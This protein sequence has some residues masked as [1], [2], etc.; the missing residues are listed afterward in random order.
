[1][2]SPILTT[3]NTANLEKLFKN[4]LVSPRTARLLRK[5]WND[6]E[7]FAKGV[8]SYVGWRLL[9]DISVFCFVIAV[10]MA[11]D[12]AVSEKDKTDDNLKDLDRAL[13]RCSPT[14][15]G[16]FLN[17]LASP[18][19]SKSARLEDV[20]K[21]Q[22]QGGFKAV[23][24]ELLRAFAPK[25]GDN[26]MY[27]DAVYSKF[28]ARLKRVTPW[29]KIFNKETEASTTRKEIVAAVTANFN[30]AIASKALAADASNP[31]SPEEEEKD[32]NVVEFVK[33][34]LAT[35]N[36][37]TRQALALPSEIF[38]TGNLSSKDVQLALKNL[39]I[40]VTE[41][42]KAGLKKNQENASYKNAANLLRGNI[43]DYTSS[44]ENALATH[45]GW[46]DS[47]RLT[48]CYLY[49]A[50]REYYLDD[51]IPLDV[52]FATWL[53]QNN[54]D[55]DFNE[56][57]HA[58]ERVNYAQK[59][60]SYLF[61]TWVVKP[62]I[63]NFT[64]EKEKL[65]PGTL[66]GYV[67][68]LQSTLQS[69]LGI[70]NKD[71]GNTGFLRDIGNR[72]ASDWHKVEKGV[73]ESNPDS[74][75]DRALFIFV[76]YS[77][78]ET[79]EITECIDKHYSGYLSFVN[80]KKCQELREKYGKLEFAELE[81]GA[82]PVSED[83]RKRAL[84]MI[85]AVEESLEARGAFDFGDADPRKR[86]Q[87]RL[88][89]KSVLTESDIRAIFSKRPE[90][91]T[92]TADDKVSIWC[93][94]RESGRSNFT[95]FEIAFD[96][97]Q[98]ADRCEAMR[99]GKKP[100]DAYANLILSEYQK[101]Y[102]GLADE[103]K[104]SLT[105]PSIN[106]RIDHEPVAAD[107]S[108]KRG[109]KFGER[110]AE[111]ALKGET[112]T[113]KPKSALKHSSA[114]ASVATT[115][116][117][118][119]QEIVA[120]NLL[121][122]KEEAK[123]PN[124]DFEHLRGDKLNTA[125]GTL[126][127]ILEDQFS[128]LKALK[129]AGDA[130]AE[131]IKNFD[132][133]RKDLEKRIAKADGLTYNDIYAME[134]ICSPLN[135]YDDNLRAK[136]YAAILNSDGY[137]EYLDTVTLNYSGKGVG[138]QSPGTLKAAEKQKQAQKEHPLYTLLTTLDDPGTQV[139]VTNNCPVEFGTTILVNYL[140]IL[141][142][143]VDEAIDGGAENIGV[144][145]PSV[146]KKIC[147]ISDKGKRYKAVCALETVYGRYLKDGLKLPSDIGYAPYREIV[148]SEE[149]KN[150]VADQQANDDQQTKE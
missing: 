148:A 58:A 83:A 135:L 113:S 48:C 127:S 133:Y 33:F 109:V 22:Q 90:S 65:P 91:S 27:A 110:I 72:L 70:A 47:V 116:K 79:Y 128:E 51:S 29:K 75:E 14:L 120:R 97:L 11:V 87:I 56:D 66:K 134:C 60:L 105:M 145:I 54:K 1:M 59:K 86:F 114:K 73:M 38:H 12:K 89:T 131:Y 10:F 122:I 81:S 125:L 77:L 9:S 45:R 53:Q 103:K 15:V 25:S 43:G 107:A 62:K 13:N 141:K 74:E 139:E 57:I 35:T 111:V 130:S 19:E 146:E 4:P 46:K 143:C 142:T 39:G 82:G 44:I 28:E 88:D 136:K 34:L 76:F 21:Q 30:S 80:G 101:A 71:L 18:K 49:N 95:M 123:A 16:D 106:P 23:F 137:E 119:K 96:W 147:D 17:S 118:S 144:L 8:E 138:P 7:A 61:E 112:A 104:R 85:H 124:I 41:V 6:P 63:P 64:F 121:I 102:D 108:K 132:V 50:F 31:I 117:P 115:S 126:K 67:N 3:D 20:K 78:C 129:N 24:V 2:P 93:E 99:R 26:P 84:S 140:P 98:L 5:S 55:L 100:Q 150:W 32:K 68:I 94:V 40:V 37:K 42:V 92:G 69:S 52:E 149:Y 36:R